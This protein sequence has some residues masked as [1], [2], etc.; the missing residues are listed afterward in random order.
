ML[1][2]EECIDIVEYLDFFYGDNLISTAKLRKEKSKEL[3]KIDL[4][5]FKSKLDKLLELI[6]EHFELQLIS[7]ECDLIISGLKSLEEE[8]GMDVMLLIDKLRKIQ[9]TLPRGEGVVECVEID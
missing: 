4:D 8:L 3:Q 2:K 9:S 5:N 1:T 6:N 7:S